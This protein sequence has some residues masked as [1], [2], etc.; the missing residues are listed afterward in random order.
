MDDHT[1]VELGPRASHHWTLTTLGNLAL[2]GAPEP[3]S[4]MSHAAWSV[5]AYMACGP[6][7]QPVPRERIQQEVFDEVSQGAHMVRNAIYV[8]RKWLGPALTITRTHLS[9]APWVSISVDVTAFL[10]ESSPTATHAQRMRAIARYHGQFLVKPQYGWAREMAQHVHERYVMTLS[11][12]LDM[13]V[14]QGRSHW[15]LSY[16]QRYVTEREWDYVAHERLIRLLLANGQP[17]RAHAH[18]V[19]ARRCVEPMP[20]DWVERMERLVTQAQQHAPIDPVQMCME[21]ITHIEQVPLRNC[22]ALLDTLAMH[23]DAHLRGVPQLV[24][25]QGE[26]G[27]GK[28]HLLKEFER[29]YADQR[30][31]WFGR[32]TG[33]VA[34]D[35]LYRRLQ[36]AMNNDVHLHA[37]VMQ[38]YAQLTP[39]QQRSLVASPNR[40]NSLSMD[41]N[42][43][44]VQR[45]DALINGFIR[46]V[47]HQPLVL[48][49]DDAPLSLVNEIAEVARQ[50]THMMVIVASE[51]DV[52][53]SA[54]A[55]YKL[56]PLSS[57][58]VDELLQA[59]LMTAVPS[60]L[61]E[62]LGNGQYTIF[63]IRTTLHQLIKSEQLTWNAVCEEWHYEPTHLADTLLPPLN[64]SM[65][66]LL[67]LIAIIDGDVA[68]DDIVVRPWGYRRRIRQLIDKL[69]E[70]QL[71]VRT[72]G[73]VRIAHDSLRHRI[74]GTLTLAKRTQLH[75][76]ALQSTRGVTQVT[77][78]L[79][80]GEVNVAQRILHDAADTAWRHGDVPLLRHVFRLI[81][82]LPQS[83]PDVQWLYAVN[84]VRMGRFGAEPAEVRRAISLLKALSSP[85]SHRHYEALIG[86][87]ISLRWAGYPRESIDVLRRVYEDAGRRR[88]PRLSFAAAHAL[89]YAY[90]DCGQV[91]HSVVMLE[92]MHAPKTHIINQVIIA[93][94][95][96]YVYARLADFVRAERSFALIN[97]YRGVL[98]ARSQALVEYHAGVIS[99]AKHDH[100]ATQRQLGSVY[101]TMYDV[102][103]MVTNL[104]AGAL[105][106]MDLVRFG[107]YVESEHL[108]HTVLERATSLQ[109]LRQRLMALFGYLH[110]LV[111]QHQWSEAKQLAEQGLKEAY[112]A[113][114]LE[115]EACL[116]GFILR[117][118]HV[119]NERKQ[120]ALLQCIDV[121]NRMNDSLAFGWYHEIAWFYWIEGNSHEALIWALQAEAKAHQYTTAAVLP[122]SIIAIVTMILQGCQHRQYLTT[123][124]RGVDLLVAH[125]RQLPS[126]SAR[127]DLV[128][129]NRGV[130]ELMETPSQTTGDVVVWLPADD[131]PR[132]RRLR[133]EEMI[134]VI[135]SG[136][137]LRDQ[138]LSLSDKIQQ[139]AHQ[140]ES[141][142]ATVMVRDLAKVL[143][144]HER[145]ILRAVAQAAEQGITIRTY[146]PRRSSS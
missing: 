45:S 60:S 24:L 51:E 8:L 128:R 112:G 9:F 42:L 91:S 55:S 48:I 19:V 10:H 73:H 23:W 118:A 77:H 101:A 54:I 76:L 106:C 117:A 95:Q 127:T 129:N 16:A 100:V 87:G 136:G 85:S 139:L 138:H 133:D 65:L 20:F 22:I 4:I 13:D 3:P 11:V 52:T 143:F 17:L 75:T 140:A 124:N 41:A 58:E 43:P 141:Q 109:L 145:T 105:M 113:G 130:N 61:C 46:F 1:H 102:G 84:A 5:L 132:G 15:L 38:I 121:H 26:S 33:S 82:Q 35:T 96:S 59:I 49:V 120:H 80:V 72:D 47:A 18:I 66:Q 99:L 34:D 107:R 81:Q 64:P 7:R 2:T 131:A 31:V 69:A 98:T 144:V 115:Y 134:P 56:S 86:A 21:R 79:Y 88:L 70:L 44:Y 119:L 93:L 116:A 32:S 78:A 146:R 137:T 104:M 122:L 63:Q 125:L 142:G 25:V 12:L 111:H 67:H 68:I 126:T 6:H 97:R 74:V 37:Q 39:A 36:F 103:D 92:S 94:T 30:V 27:T 110:I 53:Q 83:N 28:T 62:A 90:I 114:L 108:V 29:M 71:I 135:W 89:T 40:Q 50:T 123:R 57:A 14:S